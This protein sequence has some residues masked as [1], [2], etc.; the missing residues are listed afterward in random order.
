MGAP[1]DVITGAFG[2]SGRYMAGRLL[3]AGGR[4]VTLTRRPAGA[5]PLGE[6]I[7]VRPLRFARPDELVAA[8]RGAR[9]LYCTYWIRFPYR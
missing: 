4:V 8:L 1:F 7:P 3:A 2:F 5:D 6:Q 9:T